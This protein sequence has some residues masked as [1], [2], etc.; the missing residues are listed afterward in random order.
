MKGYIQ[1]IEKLSLENTDFR[2]VLYTAKHSQLVL[3][4]I[5]P[6]DEIG[7]ETHHLD[8][9]IRIEAGNGKAILDDVET[10]LEDGFA[11]VIP[12][13]TKHNIINTGLEPLKLYTVYSPPEHKDQVVRATKADAMANEEH[14]DGQTTE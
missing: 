3:M 13:G 11:V 12:A 5:Q 1:N 9:F 8:Q 14:F 10:A 2:R 6:G 7:Q 4:C